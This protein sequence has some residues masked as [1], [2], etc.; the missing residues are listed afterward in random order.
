MV[1]VYAPISGSYIYIC[2]PWERIGCSKSLIIHVKPFLTVKLGAV[3]R[4]VACLLVSSGSE[5]DPHFRHIHFRHIV[6]LKKYPSS[7]DLRRASCQL[8]V[9][10]CALNTGKLPL[11]GLLRNSVVKLPTLLI[12]PWT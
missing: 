3:A 10:K 11:G 5:S 8:L 12:L 2:A 7:A 6:L 9:Q 1:N 4:S